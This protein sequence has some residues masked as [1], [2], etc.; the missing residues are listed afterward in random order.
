[1]FDTLHFKTPFTCTQCRSP[2]EDVQ[3]KQFSNCLNNYNEGDVLE[4]CDSTG[5]LKIDLYCLE[6][7]SRHQQFAYLVVWEGIWLATEDTHEK[8]LRRFESLSPEDIKPHYQRTIDFFEQTKANFH[9]ARDALQQYSHENPPK[10]TRFL[11]LSKHSY[12][13]LILSRLLKSLTP[14]N[15]IKGS[16]EPYLTHILDPLAD[17]QKNLQILATQYLDLAQKANRMDIYYFNIHQKIE[18]LVEFAHLSIQEQRKNLRKKGIFGLKYLGIKQ[19]L[20]SGSPI[21]YILDSI[22]RLIAEKEAIAQNTTDHS[23]PSLN[24]IGDDM[25]LRKWTDPPPR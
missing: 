8:A 17:P 16:S 2:I 22:D 15:S 1:M 7:H 19:T 24:T 13:I 4:E 12:L 6:C 11:Y 9:Q 14:P 20:L 18:N 10:K 25:G 21:Q 23:S 5:V 3:T